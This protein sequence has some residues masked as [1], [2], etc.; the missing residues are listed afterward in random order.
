M[1]DP[2]Y[3][4]RDA[5]AADLPHLPAIE[6]AAATLHASWLADPSVTTPVAEL[7]AARAR[8]HLMVAATAAAPVGFLVLEP[9]DGDLFVAE[10]DVHP[11]HGR[12]GLGRRLMTAAA[13]R[14]RAAGAP[15]L[16]LTTMR[17]LPFNGPFY[18]S[19][20]FVAVPPDQLTPAW[21]AIVD[22]EARRGLPVARRDVMVLDL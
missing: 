19:L 7:D 2:A 16:V 15:R 18:A 3:V 20:G 4:I 22:A 17:D 9:L 6:A 12:R 10:V 5:V 21:R 11:D 13:D 8:G 14:A 1:I